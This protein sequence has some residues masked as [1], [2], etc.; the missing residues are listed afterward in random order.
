IIVGILMAQ[1]VLEI[2]LHDFYEAFPAILTAVFMPFTFS[3]ATGLALGFVAYTLI[4]LFTGRAA[5]VHWLMYVLTVFFG[6]Y[7]WSH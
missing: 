3:I 7:F 4:N 6:Y 1:A 2:D 5:K